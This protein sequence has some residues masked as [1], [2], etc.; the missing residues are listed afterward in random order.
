M[1][2]VPCHSNSDGPDLQGQLSIKV[3]ATDHDGKRL[4]SYLSDS[5]NIRHPRVPSQPPFCTLTTRFTSSARTLRLSV[6]P[7][8]ISINSRIYPRTSTSI[9]FVRF[10]PAAAMLLLALRKRFISIRE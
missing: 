1:K 6:I 10:T 2:R 3:S 4:T 7:F 5:P 9:F 8:T